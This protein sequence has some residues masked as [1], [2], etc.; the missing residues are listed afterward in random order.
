M[1]LAR[2]VRVSWGTI[3]G[4]TS[5]NIRRRDGG[6]H[7]RMG[8][9]LARYHFCSRRMQASLRM[10]R[11]GGDKAFGDEKK[12]GRGAAAPCDR[13]ELQERVEQ[14]WP[15]QPTVTQSNKQSSV[16]KRGVWFGRMS[17]TFGSARALNARDWL[18]HHRASP[19]THPGAGSLS[20]A[21]RVG[22][23]TG[24]A[25]VKRGDDHDLRPSCTP[26]H[27]VVI[28]FWSTGCSRPRLE[29][30]HAARQRWP[31][32]HQRPPELEALST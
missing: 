3:A 27:H 7:S 8:H 4:E 5:L 14:L 29:R 17:T 26:T 25:T 13:D 1:P 22:T 11:G 2:S 31:R 20:S 21:E 28:G 32:F 30:W 19:G 23:W 9:S 6:E 12:D 18:S 16:A 15:S 24:C 10:L